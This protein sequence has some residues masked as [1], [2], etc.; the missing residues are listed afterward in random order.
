M[1]QSNGSRNRITPAIV[2]TLKKEILIEA[3]EG[4]RNWLRAVAAG[5]IEAG[6]MTLAKAKR[7]HGIFRAELLRRGCPK[8]EVDYEPVSD[9]GEVETDEDESDNSRDSHSECGGGV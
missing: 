7:Y 8:E 9:P 6:P 5:K 3:F 4:N 2:K 1:A